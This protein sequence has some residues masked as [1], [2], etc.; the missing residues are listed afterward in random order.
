M[1]CG[2][3]TLFG[4]AAK[5]FLVDLRYVDTIWRI[6]LFLGFGGFFLL[7][8]YFFQNVVRRTEDAPA[9]EHQ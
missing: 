1:L 6:L 7:V 4:V 9:T 3:S 8:S 5:L 2:L